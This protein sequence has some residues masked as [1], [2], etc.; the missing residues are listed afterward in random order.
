M[1]EETEAEI[2]IKARA[3]DIMGVIADL[4]AYPQWC[5]GVRSATVLQ[6]FENGRPKEV[7]MVLDSG[8]I[9]DT[10]SYVYDWS[11]KN[12]VQ[13]WQ[14]RGEILA[15]L[16]GSYRCTRLGQNS[17]LVT[18]ELT[19]ELVLPMIGA[20]KRRAEKHLVATALKGLKERVES[21]A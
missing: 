12:S 9:H 15:S 6:A 4:P 3:D 5:P 1:H 17:T 18:Y 21:L 14:T 16:N 20:L 2:V 7:E 11:D 10:L 19:I 13:W 8:P